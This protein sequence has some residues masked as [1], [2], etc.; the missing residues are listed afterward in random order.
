M[1]L[2][3]EV[4][5]EECARVGRE[6]VFLVGVG[7]GFAVA[8]TYV[9]QMEDGMGGLLG[10]CGWL[11]FHEELKRVGVYGEVVGLSGGCFG[12]KRRDD[13]G[14][15]D[16]EEEDDD[17]DEGDVFASGYSTPTLCEEHDNQAT[18]SS[19]MLK[20]IKAF[21]EHILLRG[22]PPTHPRIC[23]RIDSSTPV[24]L[25]HGADD[26]EVSFTYAKEAQETLRHFGFDAT[27]RVVE[28]ETH[29]VS[30]GLMGELM[31]GLMGRGMGNGDVRGAVG[32]MLLGGW[33]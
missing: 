22:T 2:I 30:R 6:N 7:M 14:G 12:G 27:L 13:K 26:Q 4:V 16:Q 11:P 23:N 8:A 32:E 21:F 1:N 33:L 31:D 17:E 25:V 10:A 15:E 18:T 29:E 3:D 9:M 19:L 28:G 24:V 5:T 20:R